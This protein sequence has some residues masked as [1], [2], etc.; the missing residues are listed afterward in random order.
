MNK[1]VLIFDMDGT[2][3]Y[4]DS[5]IE[6]YIKFLSEDETMR[7]QMLTDYREITEIF[8]KPGN[9]T[10]IFSDK[11]LGDVWQILFYIAHKYGISQAANDEAFLNT[12]AYMITNKEIIINENL[13]ETIKRINIP[14][15]LMTNS[16]KISATPFIEYLGLED[17]FD[18]YIYDARKPL[19]MSEH[20]ENIRNKYVDSNIIKIGDNLYN[21][22]HSSNKIGIG[23]IFINHF[24]NELLNDV[25]LYNLE[26]LNDYLI[27][28]YEEV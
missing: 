24:N 11:P 16:P 19:S 13:I 27:L 6:N 14:K 15:I 22:I 4:S 10:F 20:I 9:E 25:T 12:R 23:S 2:L 26:Q 5:F 8:S 7:N 18:M 3:Y 1:D 17:V 21:D 28:K